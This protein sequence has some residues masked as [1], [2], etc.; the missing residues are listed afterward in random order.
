MKKVVSG[1]CIAFSLFLASQALAQGGAKID[2]YEAEQK[3][4]QG[5]FEGALDDYLGLREED[6]KNDSYNYNIAICYLNTN[7]NK[8]KAIPYLETITRKPKYDPNALYLLARA[9]HYAYRFDDAIKMYTAFKQTGRGNV[10]N[11]KDADRQIQFCINAKELIKFPVNVTFE[12]LG[13]NVNS[14]YAD[15]YP[16]VPNDEAFIIYNSRRQEAGDEKAGED[17][18]YAPAVYI[19]KENSGNFSKAKRFET[20]IVKKDG[21][22]EVIGLSG[23]GDVMLL[24]YTNNKG[25]GDIYITSGE[26]G[27]NYKTPEKLSDNINSSAEEIAACINNDGSVLY[28]AS[29]RS[30]GLGGTDIY[31]SIKLPNGT[32]GPAQNLGPEINTPFNEDFPNISPDGKTLFFSSNGHTTMGGYDIFKAEKEPGTQKFSNPKNLGYPVNTPEDDYN[33]R[34]AAN[35]RFGYMSAL[36]E[37]GLGDLDIYRVTFNDVEPEYSVILGDIVSAD[38]TQRLNFTDVFITV[39]NDKTNELVGTYLPNPLSGRFIMILVPGSTYDVT[40]EATG[41]TTINEKINILDKSS[42]RFEIKKDI[43]LK[44]EGYKNK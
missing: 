33:F 3:L 2:P 1:A 39:N 16:F 14:P 9:Y 7:I 6:P 29:D 8:A 34:M 24:Y 22:Q 13:P 27:K 44:P 28:F 4:I 35:G 19:S 18:T 37:G 41:F 40:I 43:K 30:G 15:Y 42:Y 36:R 26:K 10:D 5:N 25:V 21:Q 32:W 23:S 17:G 38:S 11:L 31:V 20:P 12:N